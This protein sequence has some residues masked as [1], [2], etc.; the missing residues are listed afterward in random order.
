MSSCND[1]SIHLLDEGWL[2]KKKEIFKFIFYFY[3]LIS[4]MSHVMHQVVT[5]G[6]CGTCGATLTSPISEQGL[7]E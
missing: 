2:F 4:L 5:I 6:E 1:D 3:G 7:Y